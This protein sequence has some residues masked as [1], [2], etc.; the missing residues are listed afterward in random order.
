[1]VYGVKSKFILQKVKWSLKVKSLYWLVKFVKAGLS[2][3]YKVTNISIELV[4]SSVNILIFIWQKFHLCQ[5]T[6]LGVTNDAEA[7]VDT[8]GSVDMTPWW[9]W[10]NTGSH[11]LLPMTQ[12]TQNLFWLIEKSTEGSFW[13]IGHLYS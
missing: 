4:L 5:V 9:H 7:A 8:A 10:S 12:V 6:L 11:Q 13:L 3:D 1:M 2:D